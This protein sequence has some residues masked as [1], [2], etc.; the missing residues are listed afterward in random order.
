MYDCGA[1][2]LYSIGTWYGIKMPLAKIKALCGCTREGITIQ[3]ILE[4]AGKMGLTAKAY[5]SPGKEISRLAE[6][7]APFIA[8][9]R[10]EEGYHHFIAVYQVEKEHVLIMDPAEGTFLSQSHTLFQN[11]WSGYFILLVPGVDFSRKDETGSTWIRLL[12]LL[13]FHKKEIALS[14]VGSAVLVLIGISTSIF[15]QQIIDHVLP[16]NNQTLLGSIAVLIVLLT[17]SALYIGY[18]RTLLLIRNGIQIDTRLLSCYLGKLFRLPVS[19][20]HRYTGGDIDSRIADTF[21]ITAFVSEGVVSGLISL[22]TLCAS[23]LIMFYYNAS[24]TAI[25]C[26]FIPLYAG[27][28]YFSVRIHKKYNHKLATCGARFHSNVLDSVHGILTVKHF[29]AEQLSAGKIEESYIHLAHLM[30][31]AGQVVNLADTLGSGLTKSLTATILLAGS[32]SVLQQQMSIGELVSFYTLSSLFTTP[33]NHL[34]RMNDQL[35]GAIVSSERL[36]E[37]LDLDEEPTGA[38]PHTPY[39]LPD[40]PCELTLTNL[41][42]SHIGRKAL[43]NH[44]N[45]TFAPGELTLLLGE[46]GCGKSTLAS[47][48]LRDF[49][50]QAGKIKLGEMEIGHIPLQSWRNYISIVPQKPHLFDC[51]LLEN[52]TSGEAD[53]DPGRITQICASLG[54]AP[55]LDKL[56]MGILTNVGREGIFLSGGEGQKIAVARALYKNPGILILDEATSSLD[57]TSETH[58]LDTIL[59]LK[60]QQK[61]IIMITHKKSHSRY[62]DKIIQI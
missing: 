23:L 12:G 25:V 58:I 53:P 26:L 56:P 6:I 13:H 34:I 38:S 21:K 60:E 45:A 24:L 43:F 8:H 54:L 40:T 46:S 7:T 57:E 47:L 30:Q 61:I 50:P 31:K 2:C 48:L 39:L 9:T 59:R 28:Y 4:G 10:N 37:I 27:L 14:L 52:I 17:G 16:T 36:F 3:G 35:S 32:A 5:K 33:L 19:F 44:F 11:Y 42:F 20:F 51:S 55:L 15:L 29:G 49:E 22:L 41:S 62:A 18:A 1:A